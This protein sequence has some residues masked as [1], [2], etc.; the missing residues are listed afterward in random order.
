MD[1]ILPSG[2][3]DT[4]R[5]DA[6]DNQTAKDIDSIHAV[7]QRIRVVRLQL[8][9][10]KEAEPGCHWI[11]CLTNGVRLYLEPRIASSTML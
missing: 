8:M 1:S 3:H 9:S 4:V 11:G 10:S 2:K 5:I 6:E 7:P